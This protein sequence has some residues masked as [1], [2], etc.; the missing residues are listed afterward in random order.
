MRGAAGARDDDLEA[1]RLRALG[2]DGVP[3]GRAVGGDDSRLV[4]AAELIER[5][6]GMLHGPPVGLASNDDGNRLP[7]HE[8]SLQ[9]AKKE[10]ADYRGEH[11]ANKATGAISVEYPHHVAGP[12]H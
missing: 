4:A 5:M 12:C 10:A 2:E 6:G 7:R 8:I 3:L 11:R 1:C 9:G